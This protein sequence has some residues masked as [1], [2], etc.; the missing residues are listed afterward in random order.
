MSNDNDELTK[1]VDEWINEPKQ[2]DNEHNK[3][4]VY[5]EEERARR[6]QE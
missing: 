1:L 4:G 2:G 6:L 5:P 3:S